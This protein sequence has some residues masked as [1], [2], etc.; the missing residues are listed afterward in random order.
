MIYEETSK[1]WVDSVTGDILGER[2]ESKNAR[3]WFNENGYLFGTGGQRYW[4][5]GHEQLSTL[6]MKQRGIL[7]T[8]ADKTGE[9]CIIPPLAK[10]AKRCGLSERITAQHLAALE[11]A[12][13]LKRH[14]H[15]YLNPAYIFTGKRLSPVLYELF[16]AD[17]DPVLPKSAIERYAAIRDG[18]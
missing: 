8:I 2:K 3:E 12:G 4:R 16:R 10:V 11:K 18:K 14:G 9:D 17:L 7:A 13:A 15:V 1:K 5:M 6:T